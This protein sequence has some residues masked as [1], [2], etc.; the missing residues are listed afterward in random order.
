MELTKTDFSRNNLDFLRLFFA[1]TVVFYHISALTHIPAFA[2]F[3]K[4]LSGA[5]AVK[6]FF[7]ISGML[8]YRSHLKSSS[9]ASY[10]EKRVRRIYP[11][12]FTVVALAAVAL[13]PLSTLPA[14][15]YF[16]LGFWKYV[17]ANLVFLK[18]SGTL[19]GVFTSNSLQAVNGALWTLRVEVTFYLFVPVMCIYARASARKRSWERSSASRSYGGTPLSGWLWLMDRAESI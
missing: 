15:Q 5:Y 10:L 9:L 7:V 3:G 11:A 6:S 4:Y 13:L 18:P 14:S 17:A 16:G 8:I 12:Y 19:P 1:L 2:D